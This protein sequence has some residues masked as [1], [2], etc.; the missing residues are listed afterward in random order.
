MLVSKAAIAQDDQKIFR[1]ALGSGLVSPQK[2]LPGF[3]LYVEPS[4]RFH[5]YLIGV[6]LETVGR[7]K[8]EVGILGSY[9]INAQRYFFTA[10]STQIFGGIGFGAYTV[11]SGL[12]A[13]CTCENQLKNTV[14]GFYPRIGIELKPIVFTVDYNIIQ[15]A[16]QRVEYDVPMINPTPTYYQASTSYVSVKFGWYIGIGRKKKA[17]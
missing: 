5:N 6:R 3:L 4:V 15:T 9:T 12:L 1:I 13:S 17:Q 11:N 2:V 10:G 8:A 14:V 16:T 7:P